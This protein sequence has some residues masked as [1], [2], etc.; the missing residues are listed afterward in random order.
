MRRWHLVSILTLLV[1]NVV[2]LTVIYRRVDKFTKLYHPS[3][4]EAVRLNTAEL[5]DRLTQIQNQLTLLRLPENSPV[6]GTASDLL[7]AIPDTSST[8][9]YHYISVS[10]DF[11]GSVKIYKE[12]ADFSPVLGQL[13]PGQK[14][15][16]T[17]HTASW[18]HVNLS[19]GISGWVQ[20]A[21]V[22]ETP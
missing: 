17:D 9:S 1:I 10:E 4:L 21:H 13:V 22:H 12:Q 19:G 2:G 6:L 11:T 15:P 14:Y 7:P 3:A 20:A 18:Y 8:T 16:F 5:A